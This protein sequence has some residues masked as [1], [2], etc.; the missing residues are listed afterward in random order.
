MKILLVEDD[1]RLA[2]ALAEAIG[3]QRYT[4][5]VVTDG[6]AGWQQVTGVDYDLIL[7][8][9]M[10]PKLDGIAL[11]QRLRSHGYDLPI[12][13][14]TARD[15]S[16]DKVR[17]LDAGADDYVVKPIDLA[18]LLARIRALLRRGPSIPAILIWGDLRLEPSTYE[19]TYAG[20][21]LHLTPKEYSLLETFIRNGRR[22]LSRRVLLEQVWDDRDFPEEE[23]VKAHIK[24]LR[25]KLKAV[26]APND[27]IETVHSVGYR[28]KQVPESGPSI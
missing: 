9:V 17:G 26:G 22:V 1:V 8:D 11:C 28:L 15:T 3:D 24:S 12:L 4:V 5:D 23:T 16:T 7:L 19:V 25:Q 14:I 2:E 6:E 27:L 21:P 10:L 20:Q 13:L 18:E